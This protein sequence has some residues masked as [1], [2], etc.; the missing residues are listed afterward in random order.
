MV[1]R[2]DFCEILE[3]D[4]TGISASYA[5]VGAPA[6]RVIRG[7]C[8]TNDTEGSVFFTNDNTKDKVFVK[9]GSFKL[10][11]VQSNVNPGQDD[12]FVFPIGTQWYVKQ[13]D[14]PVSGSVYIEC[15]TNA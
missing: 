2:A 11:D 4:Y 14:A 3:L 15:L 5:A 7:V 8:F 9:A 1:A 12:R 6:D 13:I 10:W